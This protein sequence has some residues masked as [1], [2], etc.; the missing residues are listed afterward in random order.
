MVLSSLQLNSN[1]GNS[2]NVDLLR[3]EAFR[4][5][6]EIEPERIEEV[7]AMDVNTKDFYATT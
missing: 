5:W 3:E 6:G 7:L 2:E 1:S 4:V